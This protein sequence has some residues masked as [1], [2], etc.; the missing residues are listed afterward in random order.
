MYKTKR[1]TVTVLGV[2]RGGAG[3]R[4][5]NPKQPLNLD[6]VLLEPDCEES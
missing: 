2:S 5:E 3:G 6:R 1:K 4:R